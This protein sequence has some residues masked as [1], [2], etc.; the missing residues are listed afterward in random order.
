MTL[1]LIAGALLLAVVLALLAPL[2]RRQTV[3]PDRSEH[4][5]EVLRD[6]LGEVERFAID[7][8]EL[9]GGHGGNFLGWM[10]RGRFAAG[11]G[12][13][14]AQQGR[15]KDK[16]EVRAHGGLRRRLPHAYRRRVAV[17]TPPGAA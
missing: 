10:R 17:V 7:R 8:G 11:R 3:S 16:G 6:Q 13:A 5:F 4:G 15:E 2:V 14:G 12:V 1:W 9:G